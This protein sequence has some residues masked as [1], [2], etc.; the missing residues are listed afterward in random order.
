MEIPKNF[1]TPHVAK[2][3]INNPTFFL[4]L[5]SGYMYVCTYTY[6][7]AYLKEFG[8][9]STHLNLDINTILRD[10]TRIIEIVVLITGLYQLLLRAFHSMLIKSRV[11]REIVQTIVTL[12]IVL[13]LIWLYFPVNNG[14]FLYVFIALGIIYLLILAIVFV[15]N[16]KRKTEAQNRNSIFSDSKQIYYG[17]N[18]Y[19][20]Y[21]FLLIINPMFIC[22]ILGQGEAFRQ[23]N[24]EV[25]HDT[26]NYVVIR[27]YGDK[28]ICRGLTKKNQMV[29]TINI[30]NSNNIK[31]INV[32]NMDLGY[33]SVSNISESNFDIYLKKHLF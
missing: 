1:F 16:T 7:Q 26:V 13:L 9:L 27:Q 32:S 11:H 28:I 12:A 21:I 18:K 5:L 4:A 23:H 3:V 2:Y 19:Y 6:E 29:D 31:S 20:I 33:L 25:I 15:K 24:F 10:A 17:F 8:I 22:H 30:I 14:L